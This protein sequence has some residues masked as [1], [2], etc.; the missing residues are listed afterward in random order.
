MTTKYNIKALQEKNEKHKAAML[1]NQISR[2]LPIGVS[3]GGG[4]KTKKKWRKSKKKSTKKHG[5]LVDG[6]L[7][8]ASFSQSSGS[9]ILCFTENQDFEK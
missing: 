9:S 2:I 6:P 8:P 1:W 4:E 5:V 3:S 7:P